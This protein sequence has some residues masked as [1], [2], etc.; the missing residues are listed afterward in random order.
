MPKHVQRL[1]A[2]KIN[3]LS[4]PGLYADGDGLYLQVTSTSAKSWVYRFMLNGKSRDMG[5]GPL[6]DISL[7]EAR[8]LA[9][10]ARKLKLARI[11]PIDSRNE[12]LL[13]ARLTE[14]RAKT[15]AECA[16]EY[17][18]AQKAGW[19]NA[20]H[21]SQWQATIDT[22]AGP[23]I[24]D[25]PVQR[26]DTALIMQILQ[27]IWII[28]TETAHRLRCRIERVLDW[29]TT[30]GFRQGENPARW[31]GHLEHMLPKPSKVY[32]VRHHPAL[33]YT[34]IGSFM[35][36]LRKQE[37]VAAL[38][39]EFLILTATRTSETIGARWDEID[40]Q[41]AVWTIPAGRIKAGRVHRVPLSGAAM[42]LLERIY[43]LRQGEFV[44]PGMKPNMPISN[45]ALLKVLE[46]MGRD[47]LTVHGFR[48]T[49]RDWAAECTNFPRDAAEMALAHAVASRV[50][51]AYRR[52]DLFEKRR[53]MMEEW[54]SYRAVE[55][56]TAEVIRLRS[57][58]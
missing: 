45:M 41:D 5:L 12:R 6:R 7:S 20:K 9:G 25:L 19:K 40:L 2:L 10:E 1:N 14:A 52:G 11:D 3:S 49:F 38:A 31:R 39:L 17:I 32:T 13:Q 23:V 15:F 55:R 37:G 36:E 57:V 24:G 42:R 54:A 34:E 27:P 48:S 16:R 50:E 43:P 8:V 58:G 29:A 56:T 47:D 35:A 30:A 28:K 22:Y 33:P 26:V 4:K 46:R 21:G 18:A 53:V 51:A 44:F